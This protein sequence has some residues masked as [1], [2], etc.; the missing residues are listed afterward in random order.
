MSFF[1]DII[2]KIFP[3]NNPQP[4]SVKE[5]LKR[6]EKYQ[7]NY[8]SWLAKQAHIELLKPIEKAYSYKKTNI[9]SPI[10]VHLFQSTGANGFA[11]T[12]ETTFGKQGFQFLMDYF[13]DVVLSSNY[14]IQT[15][16]R[17]LLD[18]GDFVEM[19]EKYYLKPTFK[20]AFADAQLCNQ[21]Y[22]NIL[23][24]YLA[25]DNQPAHL[26]VL[27]THYSDHLYMPPMDY[28]E[29]IRKLFAY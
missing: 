26:K 24:E 9:I 19:K 3:Q 8:T 27:V 23:I 1:N 21:L 25:V 10:Q 12:H 14:Y 5:I 13:K 29:L 2:H 15:A 28:D 6:N 20:I 17:H 22:G 4:I 18:K 11:I 16:E 7:K